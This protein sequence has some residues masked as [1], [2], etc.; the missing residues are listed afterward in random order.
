MWYGEKSPTQ[1]NGNVVLAVFRDIYAESLKMNN[2][3]SRK[4]KNFLIK[5]FKDFTD[6]RKLH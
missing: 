6:A 1:R 5:F 4:K 3:Q 2:L